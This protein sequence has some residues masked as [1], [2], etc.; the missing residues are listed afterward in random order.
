MKVKAVI[1]REDRT[2]DVEIVKKKTIEGKTFRKDDCTYFL[3]PDRFQV[4][5]QR[6]PWFKLW[7]RQYYSTYYYVRGQS[8]ALPVPNFQKVEEAVLDAEGKPVLGDDGK[9]KTTQTFPKML[10]NGI[11]GEEL[12]AIFNP[13][14]YRIIASQTKSAWEQIQ[15]YLQIGIAVGLI[16]VIFRLHN[17][18]VGD[19]HGLH[20]LVAPPVTT[21]TTTTTGAPGL[22]VGGHG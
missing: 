20:D 3:H 21:T 11:E 16:Y 14:F 13:W 4:T 19:I 17:L 15:F 5:W 2:N 18:S 12:A 7:R 8:Q 6:G 22:T 10:N 1:M 9:P